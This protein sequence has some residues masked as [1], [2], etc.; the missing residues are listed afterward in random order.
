MLGGSKLDVIGPRS[1]SVAGFDNRNF[2]PSV[3]DIYLAT[4]LISFERQCL[5]LY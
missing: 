4:T 1:Y 5:S 2:E 3:S